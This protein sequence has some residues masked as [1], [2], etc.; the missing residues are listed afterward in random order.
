MTETESP[1]I[2]QPSSSHVRVYMSKALLWPREIA[3]ITVMVDREW[4]IS[5]GIST[6]SIFSSMKSSKCCEFDTPHEVLCK[7]CSGPGGKLI[8]VCVKDRFPEVIGE[9]EAVLE[10]FQFVVKQH[11]TSSK[12]HLGLSRLV[13]LI[14]FTDGTSIST[15]PFRLIAKPYIPKTPGNSTCRTGSPSPSPE[16][17]PSSTPSRPNTITTHS[18]DTTT[19]PRNTPASTTSSS[20]RIKQPNR[21]WWEFSGH[22]ILPSGTFHI[23]F[24]RVPPSQSPPVVVRILASFMPSFLPAMLQSVRME[25][26]SLPGLAVWKITPLTS[27]SSSP[28]S[29]EIP[30]SKVGGEPPKFCTSTTVWRHLGDAVTGIKL[31]QQMSKENTFM[32]SG[33]VSCLAVFT[34]W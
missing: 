18:T 11:C 21:K 23:G 19:S 26:L 6:Q 17:L 7:K 33:V 28:P 12:S 14:D 4:R 24:D 27:L 29:G 15:T 16:Q 1:P 2:N 32:T 8:E 10:A 9:G 34:S 20:G 13:I 25:K 30:P 31:F 22:K 3:E 5:R